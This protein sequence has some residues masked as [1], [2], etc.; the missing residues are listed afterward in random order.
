MK[1]ITSKRHRFGK[2]LDVCGCSIEFDNS[3][4]AEIDDLSTEVINCL[5]KHGV[6]VTDRMNPV[7]SL[8]EMKDLSD[9]EI[10]EAVSSL[11]YD[12]V[13]DLARMATPE[14]GGRLKKEEYA[15][16][17]LSFLIAPDSDDQEPDSDDQESDSDD[18]E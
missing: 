4:V 15:E 8:D 6:S 9:D 1:L 2:S 12:S 13:R 16:K 7:L 10:R 18:Q 5:E 3:G 14:I 11:D 17:L